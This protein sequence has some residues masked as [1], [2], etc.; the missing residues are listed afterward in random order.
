MRWGFD[1]GSKN[2]Q[3]LANSPPRICGADQ[4]SMPLRLGWVGSS[5][6]HAE[7]ARHAASV[8][9]DNNAP[10]PKVG[11]MLTSE[12]GGALNPESRPNEMGV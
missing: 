8:S 2:T 10:S 7:I 11:A 9:G 1:R 4:S 3:S 12:P 5:S 6:G